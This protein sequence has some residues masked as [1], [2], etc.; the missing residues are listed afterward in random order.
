MLVDVRIIFCFFGLWFFVFKMIVSGSYE[1]L[2]N[3]ID[4][5]YDI[6]FFEMYKY[7]KIVCFNF[8]FKMF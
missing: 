8:R 3:F 6:D 4:L 5:F 1:S 2:M 7:V